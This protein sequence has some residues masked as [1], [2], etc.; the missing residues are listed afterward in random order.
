MNMIKEPIRLNKIAC[1]KMI[2][3]LVQLC[4]SHILLAQNE[5][6]FAPKINNF[7]GAVTIQSK[8]ISTI[9]NLT[10][11]KPAIIFDMKLGRKLTF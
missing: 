1:A 9:P 4:I 10:L 2:L 11:G 5:D 7:T 6:S 3:F 8:G